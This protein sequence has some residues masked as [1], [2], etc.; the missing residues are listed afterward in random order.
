M[1]IHT[2]LPFCSSFNCK[3][4]TQS[5]LNRLIRIIPILIIRQSVTQKALP[6]ITHYI[7]R[8]LIRILFLRK[9]TFLPLYL[10]IML[11]LLTYYLPP[12]GNAAIQSRPLTPAYI[13]SVIHA[14]ALTPQMVADRDTRPACHCASSL[15]L[16]ST[17]SS[18]DF[19]F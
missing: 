19:H 12:S 4:F 7:H 13:I 8:R 18:L 14:P 5:V 9:E 1:Y 6:T 16:S 11:I 3:K 2:I 15:P 10:Q 17:L